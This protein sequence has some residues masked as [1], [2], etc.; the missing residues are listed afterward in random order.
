MAT[1]TQGATR[2]ECPHPLHPSDLFD[3]SL[4]CLNRLLG[5]GTDPKHSSLS[6]PEGS[7]LVLKQGASN[8][9]CSSQLDPY[10]Q[11]TSSHLASGPSSSPEAT[12][13]Q[14]S[15]CRLERSSEKKQRTAHPERGQGAERKERKQRMKH[16]SPPSTRD[17]IHRAWE[18]AG[19]GQE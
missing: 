8:S 11:A 15:T 6:G 4:L 3:R 10:Q 2:A 16:L 18:G 12:A 14:N 13:T 1:G 19:R 17:D 5:Q 9:A 7:F